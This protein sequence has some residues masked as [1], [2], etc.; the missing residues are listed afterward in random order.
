MIV[1]KNLTKKYHDVTVLKNISLKFEKG[2]V[3]YI[4]GANGSGK[5]TLLK[6]IIESLNYDGKIERTLGEKFAYAP[7]KVQFPQYLSV[8]TFLNIISEN[9]QEIDSYLEKYNLSLDKKVK[10][11]KLS[12]GMY[13][14]IVI[15]GVLLMNA[16]AYIFD[17]PLSGFDDVAEKQFMKDIE[18]LVKNDKIV[19]ISTHF[20]DKY[21]ADLPHEIISLKKGLIV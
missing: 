16:D 6:C 2:K 7:E 20:Q 3:T 18:K 21:Q 9:Q 8:K 1:I 11:S 4:V 19:I 17:E 13:Q 5:S 14:K 15:I 10:F 12:K